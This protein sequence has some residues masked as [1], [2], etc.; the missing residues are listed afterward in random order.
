MSEL[1][2]VTRKEQFLDKIL[3]AAE[4]GGGGGST[5]IEKSISAN[6]V[7]NASDDSADGYSKVTVDVP[8]TY[9]AQDEGKVVD[10]GAL[11]AQTAMSSEVTENGT[12]NTTLYNSVTVNVSSGG[13]YN[14]KFEAT[15]T[16]FTVASC[17]TEIQIPTEITTIP[18][19][20][21]SSYANLAKVTMP[22]TIRT[23]NSGIFRYCAALTNVILSN[24]IDNLSEIMFQYCSALEELTI[25]NGVT[26]LKNSCFNGC[27]KLNNITLPPNLTTIEPKV[28]QDC[29]ALTSIIIPDNVTTIGNSCFSGCRGLTSIEIGS[30]V[31]DIGAS[32]F[33][34]CWSLTSIKF[35]STIPPTTGSNAWNNVPTSCKIY[36]PT[37]TLTD[38]TTAA[39]Y[40]NP[41]T[42][43]YVEY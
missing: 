38:Y 18:M 13:G 16:N 43:T 32:C 42:Y 8:N 17:L 22:D 1:T 12:V 9:T 10:N 40:P 23:I 36:V 33:G 21:F 14:A 41:S 11:V 30:S 19:N 2:P 25:P 31:T 26:I 35:K 4:S 20:A 24:N 28:F 6:G 7:Y 5:L 27:S 37:G 29:T 39:N 34:G 3:Q 15:S